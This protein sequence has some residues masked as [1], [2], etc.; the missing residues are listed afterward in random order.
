MGKEEKKICILMMMM[1]M[2]III[3]I[4]NF[5]VLRC[6]NECILNVKNAIL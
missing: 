4:I 2:K 3:I 1:M 5:T 6:R